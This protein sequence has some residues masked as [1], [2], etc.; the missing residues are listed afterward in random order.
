MFKKFLALSVLS[1]CATI[2]SAERESFLN[3]TNKVKIVG[4]TLNDLNILRDSK[5]KRTFLVRPQDISIEQR[6]KNTKINFNRTLEEKAQFSDKQ[7]RNFMLGISNSDRTVIVGSKTH[8][9]HVAEDGTKTRFEAH[10]THDS[11]K[12]IE[13]K[14]RAKQREEEILAIQQSITSAQAAAA[15]HQAVVDAQAAELAAQQAVAAAVTKSENTIENRIKKAAER[16][17]ERARQMRKRRSA[18]AFNLSTKYFPKKRSK[19]I[20]GFTDITPQNCP[21]TFSGEPIGFSPSK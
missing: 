18:E 6:R 11:D 3:S 13:R 2:S 12:Q 10:Q 5:L 19:E 20:G 16:A 17:A 9:T 15:A 8:V 1:L 21:R 4:I 14:E 7:I